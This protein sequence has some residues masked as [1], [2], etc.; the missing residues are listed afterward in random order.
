M[1]YLPDDVDKVDSKLDF[2]YNFGSYGSMNFGTWGLTYHSCCLSVSENYLFVF[3]GYKNS[4][5][6]GDDGDSR[7][8]R[9][10]VLK[11][12]VVLQKCHGS[13]RKWLKMA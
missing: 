9:N 11:Y 3:G 1:T 6:A 2:V 8:R 4:F 5:H 10:N 13:I 12:R 7:Y